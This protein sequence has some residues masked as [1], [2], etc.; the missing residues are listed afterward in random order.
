MDDSQMRACY[1][2]KHAALT[3]WVNAF[4]SLKSSSPVTELMVRFHR[5]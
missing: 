3:G 1:D 2:R 4:V 5:E